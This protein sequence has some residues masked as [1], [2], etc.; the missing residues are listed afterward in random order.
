MSTAAAADRER[1]FYR[2]WHQGRASN[3]TVGSGHGRTIVS[4]DFVPI[5][6]AS[7]RD[8]DVRIA[9]SDTPQTSG[10]RD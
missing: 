1:Q 5:R 4:L 2:K 9:V 6:P 10:Q 3:H 7:P 8:R